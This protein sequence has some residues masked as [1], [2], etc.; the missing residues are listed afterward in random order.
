MSGKFH[1]IRDVE[2]VRLRCHCTPDGCWIWRGATS[3][4]NPCAR[5]DGHS[6]PVRRWVHLRH[7]GLTTSTRVVVSD[8]ENPLCV[9]PQ[10]SR[11]ITLS[12][13]SRRKAASA[14]MRQTMRA[15]GMRRGDQVVTPRE[16]VERIEAMLA[17][18]HLQRDIVAALGVGRLVV[19]KV[20]A[21]RHRYSATRT[22]GVMRGASVFAL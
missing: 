18:G 8:C 2:D 16:T 21:G 11:R 1:G 3:S 22:G 14:H 20:A 4:G 12:E 15:N 17:E 5:I 19:S 7:H 6:T 10:H 9:A 13:A